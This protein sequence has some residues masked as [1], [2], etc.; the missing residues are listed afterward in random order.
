MLMLVILM[1]L[2]LNTDCAVAAVIVADTD[3]VSRIM[4][5]CCNNDTG[6]LKKQQMNGFN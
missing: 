6:L 4:S 5:L 1:L 2:N 3:F